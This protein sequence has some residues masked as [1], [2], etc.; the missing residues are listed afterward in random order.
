MWRWVLAL[1]ISIPLAAGVTGPK[2]YKMAQIKGWQ[3]GATTTTRW[4]TDKGVERGS[5]GRQSYWV[6]W[7]NYGGRPAESDRDWV[8]AET[9]ASMKVGDPVEVVSVP[10]DK[11][12]YLRDGV[13]VEPGNFAFDL[14]LL[15]VAACV[16]LASTGRLLWWLARGRRVPFWE[17]WPKD[18]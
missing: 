3:P 5:R 12:G 9:W 13:Y 10:G 8:S 15:A 14:V 11:A 6:T 16:A 7:A 17:G 1:V 18:W 4:I 2:L